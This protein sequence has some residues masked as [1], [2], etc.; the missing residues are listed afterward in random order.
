MHTIEMSIGHWTW[1]MKELRE[2]DGEKKNEH[3]KQN[4]Y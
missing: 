4:F 2:R 1:K 3:K